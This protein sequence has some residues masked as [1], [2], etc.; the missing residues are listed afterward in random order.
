[1]HFLC[2]LI[3]RCFETKKKYK[4]LSCFSPFSYLKLNFNYCRRNFQREKNNGE[5]KKLRTGS[6]YCALEATTE[7]SN[8]KNPF[9]LSDPSCH[10]RTPTFRAH[11]AKNGGFA[12]YMWG[13]K[14]ALNTQEDCRSQL[15]IIEIGFLIYIVFHVAKSKPSALNNCLCRELLRMFS[16]PQ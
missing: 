7:L 14:F 10:G 6:S 15:V 3:T 8:L 1:M 9:L 2:I 4:I 11:E 16:K 12:P 13:P 5:G